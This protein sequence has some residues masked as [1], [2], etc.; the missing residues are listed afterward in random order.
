M[1]VA[2]LND[3]A[4]EARLLKRPLAISRRPQAARPS[5][6]GPSA[7]QPAHTMPLLKGLRHPLRQ[8]AAGP[9]RAA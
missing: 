6:A 4:E 5:A 1:N 2:A 9:R 3:A 8:H 7:D